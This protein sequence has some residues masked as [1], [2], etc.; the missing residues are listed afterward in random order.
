[1]G[2]VRPTYGD[3]FVYPPHFHYG[4]R[5][6]E[7]QG[8]HYFWCLYGGCPH[9][10]RPSS[11]G[12]PRVQQKVG[13]KLWFVVK[14]IDGCRSKAPRHL[15][16]IQ[17]RRANSTPL[18]RKKRSRQVSNQFHPRTRS[19][20]RRK[21]RQR[22]N[23][24]RTHRT[25]LQRPSSNCS[26][27][28][29]KRNLQ[30][31]LQHKIQFQPKPSPRTRQQQINRNQERSTQHQLQCQRNHHTNYPSQPLHK[32]Q[33]HQDTLCNQQKSKSSQNLQTKQECTCKRVPHRPQFKKQKQSLRQLHQQRQRN[34]RIPLCSKKN[35]R[36]LHLLPNQYL[37]PTK[38]AFKQQRQRKPH[39][40]RRSH[41]ASIIKQRTRLQTRTRLIQQQRPTRYSSPQNLYSLQHSNPIRK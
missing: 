18:R 41:H 22:H 4:G 10:T 12:I 9:S 7:C 31:R 28:T 11:R 29:C 6:L 32:T 23:S 24:T 34:H 21:H 30:R 35:S 40:F 15:K 16:T 25:K 14:C 38:Q 33:P 37:K 36:G 2:V 19:Q 20:V 26:P 27:I 39:R 17:H 8:L 5:S 13:G 1:M 3:G